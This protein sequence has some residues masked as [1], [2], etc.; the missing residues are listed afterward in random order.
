MMEKIQFNLG[1]IK[2]DSWL[3]NL[4]AVTKLVMFVC[5]VA[6][7]IATFDIRVSLAMCLVGLS[8]LLTSKIS[9]RIYRP[10]LIGMLL[11]LLFTCLF[12]YLLEPMQG[13]Y[14]IGSNTVLITNPWFENYNLTQ[15]TAWYLLLLFTRYFATL[16]IALIFITTTN[17]SEFAC[18]LHR[19]GLSQE[20]SYSVALTLRY[21]P[22]IIDDFNNC[23]DA[24]ACRGV[25]SSAGV[26]L[27]KRIGNLTR[28]I[29][30]VLF[31]SLDKTDMI[32]NALT[33]RG[34]AHMP[35]RTWYSQK[36]I[37]KLDIIVIG[38]MVGLLGFT[39]W[40]RISSEYLIWYP[41]N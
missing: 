8:L 37:K 26:P 20:K 14:F 27:R 38:A 21:L 16:P 24:Q 4:N 31:G 10:L 7:A 23:R 17:P 18:A 11:F 33:L 2:T 32:S 5:W 28:M 41:F 6:S 12:I 22:T 19:L 34:F 39:V 25:D 30:P 3:D 13:V 29:M 15:E 35:S 40:S 36:P 1:Y 9:M